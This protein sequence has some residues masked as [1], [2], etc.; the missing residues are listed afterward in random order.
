MKL[1]LAQHKRHDAVSLA[2]NLYIATPHSS[3]KRK[4][5]LLLEVTLYSKK[6]CEHMTIKI[7][8]AC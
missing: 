2:S 3:L 7:I 4:G 8:C 1:T 5:R 6:V